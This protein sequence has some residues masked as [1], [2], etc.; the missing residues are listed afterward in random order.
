MRLVKRL[1]M[2]AGMTYGQHG[3]AFTGTI[4]ATTSGTLWTLFW[5]A[6]DAGADAVAAQ[7][8]LAVRRIHVQVTTIVAFST[9]V[10]AGR[11][12]RLVAGAATS[13]SKGE[14]TGGAEWQMRPKHRDGDV[15]LARGRVATTAALTTTGILF[16]DP[17]RR[18]SLVHMGASGAVYD[19]V[20]EYDAARGPLYL[21]PGRCLA[22]QTDAAL[23]AAGTLQIKIDVDAE[24]V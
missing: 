24:E 10:V 18:M 4:A 1:R 11:A 9:S 21:S 2:L 16:G 14:A 19:E 23:D 17:R 5:P 20:W 7:G 12:L 6:S 22:I 8:T 13:P 3:S 15:N